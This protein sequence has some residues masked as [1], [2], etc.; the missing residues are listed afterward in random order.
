MA[1][2]IYHKLNLP[3]LAVTTAWSHLWLI[4][5]MLEGTTPYCYLSLQLPISQTV[6]STRLS[7]SR[8][9]FACECVKL[10]NPWWTTALLWY[11]SSF[12]KS[13]QSWAHP[14]DKRSHEQLG[15]ASSEAGLWNCPSWKQSR[16]SYLSRRGSTLQDLRP[17]ISW[18]VGETIPI[19]HPPPSWSEPRPWP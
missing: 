5:Q 4:Q 1:S 10:G 8:S 15:F 9:M 6:L 12:K 16:G 11:K 18:H 7:F 17:G 3:R 2:W 19:S 13:V 14:K